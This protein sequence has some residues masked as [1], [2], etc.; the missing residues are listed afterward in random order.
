VGAILSQEG[1]PTTS[2]PGQ[3]PKLHPVAYYSATFTQTERNY[4][5]YEQELLAIIK[6]ISHWR[7]YLIWTKEPFTILTDHA[8]LLHWKSPRKLNCRTARWHGELQDYNFRL[9]HVPG[10][11]H[12]AADTLSRPTGADE[13]KDDNQQMTMIPE[14][15][16]IRLFGPDSDGSIEHT[17]SIIQNQN[18]TLMEEWTGIYPI[19]CVDNPDGSFWRDIK[20]N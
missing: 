13:G 7:P 14:A 6:A 3:K 12:T 10:K 18:C 11:L 19:K 1:G 20:N 9:Q 4:D 2:N 16:F 17:I 5:I 8:N 15:A